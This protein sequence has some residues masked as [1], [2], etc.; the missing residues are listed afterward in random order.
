MP[1]YERAS[2][3]I[4]VWERS[5]YTYGTATRTKL[6]YYDDKENFLQMDSL[7][8]LYAVVAENEP[9]PG[10]SSGLPA[11]QAT[12]PDD[13][14]DQ[15]KSAK[16]KKKK[17]KKEK[18][19]KD[20]EDWEAQEMICQIHKEEWKKLARA[21]LKEKCRLQQWVLDHKGLQRYWRSLNQESLNIYNTTSHVDY[22]IDRK[23][24]AKTKY[25]GMVHYGIW[26]LMSVDELLEQIAATNCPA[27]IQKAWK[28]LAGAFAQVWEM[29]K[30]PKVYAGFA[31]LV[32]MDCY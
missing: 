10:P 13:P 12:P 16:K 6:Q 29:P 25:L 23:N 31:I 9:E 3:S 8:R 24:M 5:N 21:R 1:N 20:K 28:D 32:L 19:K 30:E 7:R 18:T 2:I 27:K 17:E 15:Q 4:N 14:E 22:V 11:K 26:N